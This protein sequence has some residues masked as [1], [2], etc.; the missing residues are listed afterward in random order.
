MQT[1]AQVECPN[2]EKAFRQT[3]SRSKDGSADQLLS[4]WWVEV[5]LQIEELQIGRQSKTSDKIQSLHHPL[6]MLE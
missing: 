4:I 6:H 3:I 1:Q 2:I 5:D